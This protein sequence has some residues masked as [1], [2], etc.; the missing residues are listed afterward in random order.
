MRD[1][2][3][4]IIIVAIALIGLRRPW[5]GLLG[6]TWLSL[7]N[8]HKLGWRVANLQLAALL[9]GCTL[10]GL[11][12]T[13]DKRSPF[14]G[15]APVVLLLFMLWMCVTYPMSM[16]PD[17]VY[18]MWD[19]V[20][21]IDMMILVAI[22][23]IRDRTQ[24]IALTWVLVFSLG[25]YGVK[26]GLFT[27][28]TGGNFR[29][30]GPPG[31]FIEGNNE[32]ALAFI[33]TIPLIR[34]LQMQ[35]PATAGKLLRHA[36]TGAMLLC[37]VAALGTHSRGALLAVMAMAL[38]LWWR[39]PN[40]LVGGIVMVVLGFVMV[41]FMPSE[42]TDRM[43]TIETYDKD[44]SAMGRINAWWMAWNL[45]KDHFFGG[46]YQIYNAQVFQ[47]YAPDPTDVHAAH[48]IYF[49]V[50]GEHGFIGLFLFMLIWF[51]VW[52]DCNW[53][54]KHG[55][56]HPEARWA[57]SL[58]AMCQVSLVGYLVGGAFLSLAYFDLPYNLLV[59]AVAARR[60]VA[61]KGWEQ[62]PVRQGKESRMS[63]IGRKLGVNT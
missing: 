28:L 50:L 23:L 31:T 47:M 53:L 30:W 11:L 54:R 37:V 18:E 13:R 14:I 20:M 52:R 16:F 35:L 25:F 24:I 45:A 19:K 17:Q 15:A 7:M 32:I 29:V 41:G 57:V 10:L 48:S 40:K 44:A 51:C 2:A 43:N 36:F 3:I 60:W 5:I 55:A 1:I 27:I 61:D 26:G 22:M 62:E 8:V 59:L 12:I 6:W 58:G 38:M 49:Q 4:I 34:F 39:S 9:A 33:I 42:W 56:E 46:G 63:R 21:K